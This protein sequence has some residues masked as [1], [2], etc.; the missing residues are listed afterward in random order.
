MK[1][2]VTGISSQV[3]QAVRAHAIAEGHAVEGLGRG[4]EQRP[5]DV[6]QPLDLKVLFDLDAVIHLAWFR[7]PSMP[8]DSTLDVNV[9]ASRSLF[10]ACADLGIPLVFLSSSSASQPMK[11]RYGAAKVAVEA[12]AAES[13]FVSLRAGLIWGGG[14]SPILRALRTL[15]TL[16]VVLPLP[17]PEMTLDHN[18]QSHVACSLVSAIEKS[19]KNGKVS[20]LASPEFVSSTEVLEAL[21]FPRRTLQIPVPGRFVAKTAR[22]VRD[23]GPLAASRLDSVALLDTSADDLSFDPHYPEGWGRE[24]FLDWLNTFGCKKSA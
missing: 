18:H 7:D 16:P 11:S 1:I 23:R 3:G 5:F 21:R 2:G 22:I 6:R 17:T 14:L 12:A 20:S 10:L 19:V 13:G 8:H 24:Q 15:A 4:L 9:V